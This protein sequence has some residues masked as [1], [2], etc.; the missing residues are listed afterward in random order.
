MKQSN[1]KA[2]ILGMMAGTLL[3]LSLQAQS[4]PNAYSNF[5]IVLSLQFHAFT[6]HF[7][8]IK[9]NFSNVGIGIGTEASFGGSNRWV[10]QV[11]AVWYHNKTMGNGLLFYTQTAWRPS[12][13]AEGFTEVKAGVGYLHSFR[14]TESLKQVKGEWVTAGHHGKGMLTVPVG[15]SVGYNSY[16]NGRLLSPFLTYQFLIAAG[17]NK[18]IPA[19]PYT[20]I[21]AGARIHN[22]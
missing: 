6:L 12:I 20:L 14:P 4:D 19:V 2:G 5:P 22:R 15:V 10:Q 18:S 3:T 11:N 9:A 7:H 21:Q 17:Y 16:S 13:G 8:D 1:L